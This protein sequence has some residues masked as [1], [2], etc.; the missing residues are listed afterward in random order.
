M[1]TPHHLAWIG[2]LTLLLG[3]S[4]STSHAASFD[5]EAGFLGALTGTTSTLDFESQSNGDTVATG[6]SFGGIQFDYNINGGNDTMR[7]T[8]A[9]DGPSGALSNTLGL[10]NLD[11]AFQDGD[12]FDMSFDPNT[13]GVG[14]YVITSDVLLAGDVTLT[15]AEGS[16][17]NTLT[18]TVLGDGG[19]A[20]FVGFTAGNAF[21][22][23]TLSFLNDQQVHFVFN[24]DDITTDVQQAVVPEPA[25]MILFG[26]GLLGL[27]GY[28]RWATRV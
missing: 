14:M 12:G 25:T 22:M 7:V 20:Y 1:K 5:T 24:L 18:H 11:Q 19:L 17:S 8:N 15:T 6:G 27:V 2:A 21:D 4:I 26:S 16:V 10:D 13:T 23:A 3:L 28:R 9:Y